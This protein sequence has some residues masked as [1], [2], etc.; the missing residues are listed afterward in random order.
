MIEVHRVP[1]RGSRLVDKLLGGCVV[2]IEAVFQDNMQLVALGLRHVAVDP[3]HVNQ[4]CRRRKPVVIVLKMV[5]RL[6]AAG[7][8]RKKNFECLEHVRFG[9]RLTASH[10]RM[11]K[12]STGK[13][14]R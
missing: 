11:M 1:F 7:K 9:P 14:E 4:Q 8:I 3:G 5:L 10:V 6:V 12:S 2:E 13:P